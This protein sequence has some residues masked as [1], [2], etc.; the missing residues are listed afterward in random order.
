MLPLGFAHCRQREG[1][2]AG[3]VRVPGPAEAHGLHEMSLTDPPRPDCSGWRMQA[4]SGDA[5]R[6]REMEVA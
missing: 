2:A 3:V 5:W 6:V 4:T 1:G